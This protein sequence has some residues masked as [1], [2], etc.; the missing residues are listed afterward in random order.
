ML[1]VASVRADDSYRIVHTYPHD[2]RAYTQ[3]LI[4]IDGHLYE[5]TGLNGRS[6]LRMDDL[7]TGRVLQ[8]RSRSNTLP[9]AWPRGAARCPAHL[10]VARGL[11][12]R[13]LQL[14]PAAH[15]SLRLRRLG[16]DR[17]QQKSDPLGRNRGN[18]FLRSRNIPRG[19]AHRR[20][21]SRQASRP[22][23]RTRIHS[24]SDLRQRVAHRP[25]RCASRPRRAACWAGSI[26]PAC[27]SPARS[28]DQEALFSTA[29]PTT[30]RTTV[31]LSPENSGPGFSKSRWFRRRPRLF[32]SITRG[33][34]V[35][36]S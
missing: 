16:P 11:R 29:S 5:S 28:S 15:A 12:L 23:E 2:P 33:N 19:A 4:Y 31:S 30:R 10:A 3:G 20:E 7:A 14:S 22:T 25:H 17:R 35:P 8:S 6:S 9:R 18:S 36:V 32:P 27:F 13:P 1:A 26:W 21:G 34:V 24:R